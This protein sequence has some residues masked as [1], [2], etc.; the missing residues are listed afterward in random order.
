MFEKLHMSIFGIFF[1]P[2]YSFLGK[3]AYIVY[4]NTYDIVIGMKTLLNGHDKPKIIDILP[5]ANA[6]STMPASDAAIPISNNGGSVSFCTTEESDQDSI[7]S[8]LEKLSAE[9]ASLR[10]EKSKLSMF[11]EQ[12]TE[13]IKG[14]IEIRHKTIDS[15][16]NEI[17]NTKTE[18]EKLIRVMDSATKSGVSTD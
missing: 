17:T 16:K 2:N 9:E 6:A 5:V 7:L 4:R 18:C 8:S 13:R 3:M 15:L 1:C 14:E 12:L 10:D 11:K